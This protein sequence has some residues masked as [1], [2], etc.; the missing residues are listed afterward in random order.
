M[1]G[2]MKKLF[3]SAALAAALVSLSAAPAY[4]GTPS[5]ADCLNARDTVFMYKAAHEKPPAHELKILEQCKQD[6]QQSVR[7]PAAQKVGLGRMFR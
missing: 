5:K 4:A 2:I 1:E 7:Q 6:Q 3:L